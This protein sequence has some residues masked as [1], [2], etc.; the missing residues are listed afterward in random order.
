MVSPPGRLRSICCSMQPVVH[1]GCSHEP[2]PV[3]SQLAKGSTAASQ[4]V[5]EA[6]GGTHITVDDMC[7]Q[8]KS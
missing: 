7:S 1:C 3:E 5:D 2:E 8:C 6:N 4:S